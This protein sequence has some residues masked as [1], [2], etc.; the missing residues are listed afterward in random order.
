MLPVMAS[1]SGTLAFRA[2]TGTIQTTVFNPLVIGGNSTGNITLDPSNHIAGGYVAANTTNVS[3]L[4]TSSLLWRNVYAT[5]F[6]EGASHYAVCN[7]NGDNC[8]ATGV[9]YWALGLGTIYPG[10]TTM[11]L[12]IGNSATASAKFAFINVLK[13]TPTASISGSTA[14][15]ATFIDGNGNISSTLRNSITIGNSSTYNTTGNVL[16]NPNGFGNIGIG[17]SSPFSKLSVVAPSANATG[18][19]AFLVDQYESQDILTASASGTTRMVL[20]N[21]GT[22]KLLGATSTLSNT[23]GDITIDAASNFISFAGDSLYNIASVSATA[24]FQGAYQVCDSGG[25]HCPAGMTNYWQLT[26]GVSLSPANNLYALNVGNTA[27]TSAYFHVPGINNQNAWFNLGTGNLGIGTTAPS[28]P[29]SVKYAVHSTT[30]TEITTLAVSD[31]GPS[32]GFGPALGFVIQRT[33]AYPAATEAAQIYADM[34]SLSNNNSEIGMNILDK[35]ALTNNI[36]FGWNP[37]TGN[38]NQD[39]SQIST[40]GNGLQINTNGYN[41]IN[42]DNTYGDLT[43]APHNSSGF[44]RFGNRAAT[45]VGVGINQTGS[46]ALGLNN[47]QTHDPSFTYPFTL[48]DRASNTTNAVSYITSAGGAYFASNIGIETTT[49]TAVLDIAGTA[50]LSGTLAFRAGT[51]TIQTTVFNPLVIGGNS[52]GN[53]TLDPSNHIAG[54]YVAANTNNVSDLGTNALRWRN[55]YATSF[56]QAGNT[57]CDSTGTGCP[58]GMT[59][60]WQLAS[61]VLAPANSSDYDLAVGGNSTASAR[62]QVFAATGDASMSGTLTVGYGDAIRSQYGPLTLAYKSGSN[63]WAAGLTV[64]DVTGQIKVATSAVPTADMVNIANTGYGVTSAGVSGIQ[65]SYVAGSG[66]IEASAERIDLTSNT[67]GSGST[68]NGYR[69]VGFTPT[70]GVSEN[71]IKI[72]GITAGAGT[73]YAVNIGTGWSYGIYSQTASNNY[74]AGNVGIGTSTPTAPLDVAGNAS[75]SGTLAFRAG[76]GTIQTTVFN[77]LVI[78]GNST[79]NITLDPSNHIAGGYVA[80]N[81]NNVSDLGTNAL[82]WRNI[83]ATSF[84]QAGNTVC[85]STGTGCPAG[86]T[87]YWQLTGGVSL[88]PAN[89]LYALNV[90]NTASTSAFFHAPGINNQNAWFNLGTGNVGIGTTTPIVTLDVAGNASV[91]GT[92]AFRA[93]TGTIQTTVFNPLVI[94]GNSTGNITLDPSNHIAGGYVAPNTNNVSDLGT[95]TVGWR[96][97]YAT[98]FYEG[99]SHY[100]VCDSNGDNCPAG[101]TNYWQLTGGVSLSP[102]NNLYALNVGNTASTS[103]STT[104]H[105]PGI[106]NNNAW[107]NLGTGSVGIGTT[108]PSEVLDVAGDIRSTTGS[109]QVGNLANVAYSRFSGSATTGHSLSASSDVLI[110]GGLELDGTLFLDSRIITSSNGTTTISFPSSP[111]AA[112]SYNL[113]TNGSWLIQNP[114]AGNP[115]LA[116]LMV[117]QTKGGDIFSASVSGA[118]KFVITNAGNVIPGATDASDIGTSSSLEFRNIYGQALFQGANQVCD[119]AGNHCPAG[120]T[121][122][123]QLTG[124]VSLSPANNLYAL[125]VGNTASASAYFH[126]PGI[127]NQNAWF[128]LG[129]GNLGLGT[130]G[131]DGYLTI[132]HDSILASSNYFGIHILGAQTTANSGSYIGIYMTPDYSAASGNTLTQLAGLEADPYNASTGAISGLYGVKASPTNTSSGTVTN[133]EAG[134]FLAMDQG[135]GGVSSLVGVRAGVINTNASATVDYGYGLL[136]QDSTTTGVITNDYGLYQAGTGEHNYFGGRVGVGN[137]NATS[138]LDVSGTAGISPFNVASSSGSSLLNITATGIVGIGTTTPDATFDINSSNSNNGYLALDFN[139]NEQAADLSTLATGFGGALT[140]N[141][142]NGQGEFDLISRRANSNAGIQGYQFMQQTGTGTFSTLMT[143]NGDTGG[144]GIAEAPAAMFDVL[145]TSASTGS[146]YWNTY[147]HG[148]QTT[149]NTGTYYGELITPDFSA[150][151]GNTLAALVGLDVAP[152]NTTT[153]TI[154]TLYGGYFSPTNQSSGT[155]GTILGG[156]FSPIKQGTGA[157][158]SMYALEVAVANNNATGTITN[159]YA[160]YLPA[161]VTVGTIT[162]NFGIYQSG[163]EKNSFAGNLGLGNS[164]PSFPLE[165]TATTS[166]TYAG[167]FTRT[168]TTTA[169]AAAALDIVGKTTGDMADS[170][171]T[172]ITLSIQDNTAGPNYIGGVYAVRYGSD[173]DGEMQ[174]W[175][176]SAATWSAKMAI[177]NAGSVGIGTVTPNATLHVKGSV[178]V[179]DVTACPAGVAGTIRYDTNNTSFDL[180]EEYPTSESLSA[181]EIVTTGSGNETVVKSQQVYDPNIIGIVS[182]N[183]NI[184]FKSGYSSLG[185]GGATPSAGTAV[186]T[187]AGRVPLAVSL[188]NGPIHIGDFLTSSSTPGVA[189]KATRPGRVVGKALENYTQV[190]DTNKISTFVN[191]SWY[192]P[193]VYLTSIGDV[194]IQAVAN[195][196]DSASTYR[197]TNGGTV[198]DRIGAFANVVA[199]NVK[200]GVVTT[201]DFVAENVTSGAVTAQNL[202][203]QGFTAFQGTVDNLLIRS[204]LVAGNIQTKLISPL[205][206]GTDVTVQV[207]STS[208][209]SG[210]FVVQNASGS[211]VAS[212]DNQGNA[213]FAGNASVS[214]TLFADEIKSKSLDDIQ[215]LLTSVQADQNLLKDAANWNVLTATNSASLDELA[216]ADLYV[217]NQ[218]AFNSLSVTNALTV[219]PDMVIG[220]GVNSIDTLSAPLKLQSLA[221]APLEIMAGLVTIDTHGNVNIA[222]DLYVAGRIKSSGLTL[223]ATDNQESA[224]ASALLSLQNSSGSEVA[225]VNAGG[226]AQ[227]GSVSTPQ[228]VIAGSDATESG[229]IIDGVITTNSTVGQAV[230]PAGTSEI[231]IKNPKVTD[232]TLI[233]VTPTSSTENNVLYV[234]SKQAGQFVV[235]FANSIDTDVSFNWWIVQ[236]Q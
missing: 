62:F 44:V 155:I 30:P 104:F 218:A 35:G 202:V 95:S 235:G 226:N 145:G 18:K 39:V 43:I 24:V 103:A 8:P 85:D 27:S 89:N 137:M 125:N 23:A 98:T 99:A 64:S 182:T 16:L 208:T 46:I 207:G 231:T 102:A 178:C 111:T 190:T 158:T 147:I 112:G 11:D 118:K 232:Y 215:A 32:N 217:T 173:T 148:S 97:V 19:A 191:V 211:A 117:D 205:A 69:M 79:G 176:R 63:T 119:S 114:A 67:V 203:A 6:Y 169:A 90:G 199:A 219:G 209:P 175:T 81:T 121:N 166:G 96:N 71:A 163:T 83:Y 100:A 107:F 52:T 68:W 25:N 164:T 185:S 221:M 214:G 174:F 210:Q 94:G 162:N 197:L 143:I 196:T 183:P 127:N 91:S 220:S 61:H 7:S 124:S 159:G 129:T 86:I 60:Y 75:V 14:G 3:D 198:I 140:F 13:N 138:K 234:K 54:G 40:G 128:N 184:V 135:T 53:I 189:M 2:G 157:V 70:S 131:P 168:V 49:P 101:G 172:G 113:L 93:G 134:S 28:T 21:D 38:A 31:T 236:V 123:W 42:A 200:A 74:F 55:I 50:S 171:G 204:G 115:G 201:T 58:A 77:P 193:D 9:N 224:T 51:G 78:G 88:S 72:D 56:Y 136:I 108:A 48:Y 122:Y 156:V 15:V 152:Q 144:V 142:T 41:I 187:L 192:D 222:G 225:S 186:V 36:N 181:G 106:T 153:G 66:A 57:V 80:A 84:Y 82:R 160:I 141:M 213:A 22:L 194:N 149:A 227:F 5:T 37:D 179:Q 233:Y 116:A 133:L 206:D 228:L 130:T 177:D 154:T 223:S 167:R 109:L 33:D 92:L 65:I 34:D 105:V 10:N 126:V 76:T 110:G 26:G 4:G 120:M 12:L 47:D 45:A 216:V 150:T 139:D 212:I 87:N 20:A 229:T 73:G 161:S 1:V 132:S 151:T 165:A 195:A 180:A 17:T 59:N 29:L 230:I 146:D 188:E 170:H